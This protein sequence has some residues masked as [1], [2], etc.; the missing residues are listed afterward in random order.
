VVLLGEQPA[1]AL[2]AGLAI[3]IV[4]LALYGTD[5]VHLY[6]ARKRRTVELNSRM[7]ALAL[8]CLAATV[9]LIVVLLAL[10][11]L[12]DQIGA[13]L[14]LTVFGWRSGLGLAQLYK[15]VAFLTWLECYG[16]VLGKAPTPRVQDLVVEARAGRWFLLYF[17]AVW[18]GTA[19]LIA[20]APLGF[21]LAAAGLLI[22]TIG[23]LAQLV[24]TRRLADVN[25]DGRFPAGARRPRLLLSCQS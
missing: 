25:A 17:V 18:V 19:A 5:I 13:V 20:G 16:P 15:I 22:A 8:A 3:G 4:A 10:G 24:R 1:L 21:R 2:L 12:G 23:I 11:R 7:A 14:F 6:R 9:V